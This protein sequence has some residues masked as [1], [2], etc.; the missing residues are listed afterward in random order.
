MLSAFFTALATS[1]FVSALATL[2]AD[3]WEWGG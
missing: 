3:I 2:V 1:D